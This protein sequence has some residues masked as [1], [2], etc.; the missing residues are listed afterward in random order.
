MF[1]FRASQRT[2]HTSCM[3]MTTNKN[4]LAKLR[5]STGYTFANC[6]KALEVTN[7]DLVQVGCK[8]LLILFRY[9]PSRY[10]S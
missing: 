2:F 8:I 7:N 3:W 10:I 6:K 1:I 5:K 4:L 9:N